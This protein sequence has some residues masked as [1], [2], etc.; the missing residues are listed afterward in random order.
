MTSFVESHVIQITADGWLATLHLRLWP[1]G[2][3]LQAKWRT[4]KLSSPIGRGRLCVEPGT[5]MLSSIKSLWFWV[6][7]RQTAST[8]SINIW[9]KEKVCLVWGCLWLPFL[10][11]QRCPQFPVWVCQSGERSESWLLLFCC[12]CCCS[13]DIGDARR[14]PQQPNAKLSAVP[15][16]FHIV[17]SGDWNLLWSASF[18]TSHFS[19]QILN[20]S[21]MIITSVSYY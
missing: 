1:S 19:I 12:C 3:P 10:W 2:I 4:Q 5:M 9:E 13:L 11:L 7:T 18:S 8:P 21:F 20:T 6:Y 16:L 15:E 14:L 17:K